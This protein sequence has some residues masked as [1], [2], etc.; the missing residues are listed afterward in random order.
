MPVLRDFRSEIIK[1]AT[2]GLNPYASGALDAAR[3]AILAAGCGDQ[4]ATL[5][6]EAF[7]IGT[8]AGAGDIPEGFAR[9]TLRWAASRLNS[10]ACSRHV[11][12]PWRPGEAEAKASRAFD[13]GLSHPRRARHG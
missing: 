7:A 13:A 5:N 11:N 8:L 10:C 4:E 12:N 6:G 9:D 2:P 1:P 3:R